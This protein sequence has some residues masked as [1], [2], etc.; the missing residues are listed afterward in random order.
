MLTNIGIPGLLLIFGIFLLLFGAK[1]I[2]DVAESL[3]KAIKKF[4]DT[5]KDVADKTKEQRKSDES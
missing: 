2:P 5:Q 3:G 4:Q 1:R